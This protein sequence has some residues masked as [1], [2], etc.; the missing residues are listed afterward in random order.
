MQPWVRA[1]RPPREA[2]RH[3]PGC[4]PLATC[5]HR[6]NAS[7]AAMN[8]CIWPWDECSEMPCEV[9]APC[10]PVTAQ[11]VRGCLSRLRCC[12]T[13]AETGRKQ[14]VPTCCCVTKRHCS[15][16][17][18]GSLLSISNRSRALLHHLVMDRQNMCST[19]FAP[20]TYRPAATE[21][22]KT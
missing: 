6:K 12:A 8:A 17:T 5:L 11:Q 14:S 19:V 15:P 16:D 10:W 18:P 22:V 13:G 20:S 21:D 4:K 9:S 2:C 7:G 3:S 1:M